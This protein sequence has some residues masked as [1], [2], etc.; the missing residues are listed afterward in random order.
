[1]RAAEELIDRILHSS[2]IPPGRRRRE[3]QRELRSHIEDVVGAARADGQGQDEIERL[4]LANFG[5]PERIARGFAWVYRY[6]RRRLRIVAYTLSTVVLASSL[7]ASI[8]V[9][10]SGLALSFGTPIMKV[11]A[12]RHTMI[13]ALDILASVG[14][15]LGLTSLETFFDRRRFQKA[16]VLLMAI[17]T[18]LMLSCAAAG[19]HAIFLFFGLVNGVFFRAVKLFVTRKVARLVIVVV[20]FPLA[21]IV[22]ALVRS[23]VS[24]VALATTCISWLFMGVGYQLMTDLA[25]RVDAAL[26]SGLQRIQAG[27]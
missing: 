6:E 18:V 1:M 27:Y 8:L 9:M 13:E 19:W 11:L 17:L 3:V 10:Q 12:S 25:T 24:Q 5:D 4:V 14:V 23:P 22:L 26:V 15:Y 20:C 16:A 2:Q 21:G 7:L